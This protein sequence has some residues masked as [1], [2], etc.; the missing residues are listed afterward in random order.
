MK[1]RHGRERRPHFILPSVWVGFWAELRDRVSERH[2]HVGL[3]AQ[4]ALAQTWTLDLYKEEM[5]GE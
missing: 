1:H 5:H 3:G 4:R 2:C